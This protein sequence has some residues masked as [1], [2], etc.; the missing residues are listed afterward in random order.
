MGMGVPIITTV[1]GAEGIPA[2]NDSE[3]YIAKN[4]TEF[5]D[6]AVSLAQSQEKRASLGAN[7]KTFIESNYQIE[8]VTRNLIEFIKHIS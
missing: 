3:L 4:D 8:T 5:I 1:V 2:K 6:Y 7:A